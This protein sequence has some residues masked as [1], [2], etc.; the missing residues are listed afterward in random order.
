MIVNAYVVLAALAVLAEVLLGAALVTF[1]VRGI[2]AR[3]TAVRTSDGRAPA[4]GGADAASPLLA[5]TASRLLVATLASAVLLFL[6]LRSFVPQW[7]GVMCIQGVLRVGSHDTGAAAWLPGLL[8]AAAVLTG[9]TILATG[10]AAVVHGI[11]RETRTAPLARTVALAMALAGVLAVAQGAAVAAYL[12]IPKEKPSFASG[13]CTVDAAS[14]GPGATSGP[15]RAAWTAAWTAAFLGVGAAT[16]AGSAWISRDGSA[17]PRRSG[18][19]LAAAGAAATLV[20]G[21]AFVHTSLA[22]AV[23]H[24]PLHECVFCALTAAPETWFGLVAGAAGVASVLVGAVATFCGTTDEAAA[25]A[26]RRAAALLRW[27]ALGIGASAVSL[28]AERWLA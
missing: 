27:G 14:L 2:V 4:P 19:A 20:T 10:V 17:V 18:V 24:L 21:G 26:A 3:G 25:P 11:D 15:A 12:A 22:P 16:A 8:A 7:P 13:C 23:Q 6:V 1:A 9:G 28:G 5:A